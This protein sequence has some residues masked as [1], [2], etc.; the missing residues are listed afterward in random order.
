MEVA[1]WRDVELA[2]SQGSTT[3]VSIPSFEQEDNSNQ[4]EQEKPKFFNSRGDGKQTRVVAGNSVREKSTDVY[5][6][7][8]AWIALIGSAILMGYVCFK[9]HDTKQELK[10]WKNTLNEPL[11]GGTSTTTPHPSK[12]SGV[13]A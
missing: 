11:V 1:T 7:V 10:R 5:W 12:T 3:T 8:L 6:M 9:Y 13:V 4:E 2:A